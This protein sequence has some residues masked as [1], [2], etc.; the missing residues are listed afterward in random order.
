MPASVAS[1][2]QAGMGAAQ[3]RVWLRRGWPAV[4]SAGSL[5]IPLLVRKSEDDAAVE[6]EGILHVGG[7]VRKLGSKP[8]S[9]DQPQ[10]EVA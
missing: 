10:R 8:V 7:G 4:E 6:M 9:M 2:R 5:R 1:H 3:A